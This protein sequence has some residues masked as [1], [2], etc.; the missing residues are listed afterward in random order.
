M[1][2]SINAHIKQAW[3][4]NAW[5]WF[6]G[7]GALKEGQGVCYNWDYGTA[8]TRLARRT[9]EVEVPTILNAPYFAGVAT[10]AYT[11]SAGGQMIEIY[12]PG[13][14]CNVWSTLSNTIGVGRTTCQAGAG[15]A[16]A[17]HF[18]LTG[19]PGKG[20]AIPLQTIDRSS[21][22]GLCLALLEEGEQSGLVENI[23]DYAGAEAVAKVYMVGGVSY[24]GGSTATGAKTFVLADGTKVGQKKAF[25]VRSSLSS[26]AVTVTPTSGGLK[27]SGSAALANFVMETALD[28]IVLEWGGF[29]TTSTWSTIATIAVTE[30]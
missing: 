19:F 7:T 15:V 16:A 11:A 10:R 6:N 24:F 12:L 20:S 28:Y 27:R 18:T 8:A 13:S 25:V 3:T 21:T 23:T 2:A 26:E 14:T 29:S 1:D 4:K 17:G 9:N 30:N 5:V 22:A